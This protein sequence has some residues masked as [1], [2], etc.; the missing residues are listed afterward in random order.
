M[1]VPISTLIP[2]ANDLVALEVEDAAGVL[3]HFLNSCKPNECPMGSNGRVNLQ[4]LLQQTDI[5]R[6]GYKARVGSMDDVDRA[7]IEAWAWLQSEAFLVPDPT[8]P[9][10][11]GWFLLS[12]RAQRL[13]TRTDV[14]AYRK[15]KLLPKAQLHP[16]LANSIYPPFLQ[17]K[18]DAAIFEAFLEVEVAVRT[19][20][21]YKPSDTGVSL[22]RLAFA[23][24]KP[25][26][27]PGPLTD[28]SLPLAEQE[29]TAHMFAGA[30]GVYR[31]STGHRKVGNTA[32]EAA[33]I[34]MF[35]SQLLR[36]VDRVP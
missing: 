16:N 7:V 23:P 12:K 27:K 36:I 22:M 5:W 31:N 3:L 21:G 6:P 2:T 28:T 10:D 1:P 9:T 26:S 29:A 32:E 25:G 19:K 18:Y 30:M 35:A 17:G 11:N 4:Q 8:Q 14:D 13:K 15:A 24:D 20:G 33:E 34:V